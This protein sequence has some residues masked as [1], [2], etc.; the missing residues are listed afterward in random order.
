MLFSAFLLVVGAF[1]SAGS[2]PSRPA[3]RL[4]PDNACPTPA[5]EASR[6]N[7]VCEPF[8]ETLAPVPGYSSLLEVDG[9]LG[10]V[11]HFTGLTIFDLTNPAQPVATGHLIDDE[12]WEALELRAPLLFAARGGGL[13]IWDLSNPAQP[14]RLGRGWGPPAWFA[15][16]IDVAGDIAFLSSTEG[17][18]LFD[19]ADP[20]SPA[21]VRDILPARAEGN[22]ILQL[23]ARGSLLTIVSGSGMLE[24]YDISNPEQ[25]VRLGTVSLGGGFSSGNL[26]VRGHRAWVTSPRGF[27]VVDLSAPASPVVLHREIR[28]ATPTGLAVDRGLLAIL[29]A[30]D[31]A[32]AELMD[33][34]ASA[35]PLSL[36]R[37]PKDT[38]VLEYYLGPGY[39]DARFAGDHLLVAAGG[40]GLRSIAIGDCRPAALPPPEPEFEARGSSR[41]G[42]NR[43]LFSDRS[44]GFP[45]SWLWDFGDGTTSIEPDP[46]HSFSGPGTFRVSLTVANSAGSSS[47]SHDVIVAT[48]TRPSTRFDWTPSSPSPGQAATFAADHAGGGHSWDFG[49]PDSGAANSSTL[50]EPVH[51]F[52]AAGTYRVRLEVTDGTSLPPQA[53]RIVEVSDP[54]ACPTPLL[55]RD[56]SPSYTTAVAADGDLLLRG[57]SWESLL[58]LADFSEPAHPTWTIASDRYSYGDGEGLAVSGDLLVWRSESAK[59]L[60]AQRIDRSIELVSSID[61]DTSRVRLDGPW[62]FAAKGSD[63]RI[64]DLSA[65]RFPKEAATWSADSSIASFTVRGSR[66]FAGRMDGRLDVVDISDRTEPVLLGSSQPL[67]AALTE[68]LVDETVLWARLE[69]ELQLATFDLSSPSTPVLADIQYLEEFEGANPSLALAGDILFVTVERTVELFDVS[70]RLLPRRFGRE[71]LFSDQ[72]SWA[73]S[74]GTG[75]AFVEADFG[76]ALLY[77]PAFCGGA[78]LP[79]GAEFAWSPG[80]IEPGTPVQFEPI[81]SGGAPTRW[82]WDFGDGTTSDREF[83]W[84]RW[85]ESGTHRVRLTVGNDAG[86]ATV[87]HDVVVSPLATPPVAVISAWPTP[88]FAGAPVRFQGGSSAGLAET[89]H[90]DFGDGTTAT[91]GDP[92][93]AFA[94]AG[95]RT[96]TLT[97]GNA[98]GISTAST[99]VRVEALLP[100]RSRITSDPPP[101]SDVVLRSDGSL[102]LASRSDRIRIIDVSDMLAIRQVGVIAATV[103]SSAYRDVDLFGKVAYVLTSSNQVVELW[104]LSTPQTPSKIGSLS[105]TG[106]VAIAVGDDLLLARRGE[107]EVASFLLSDPR[108]PV[109]AGSI[110]GCSGSLFA[111]SGRRAVCAADRS[112]TV[113]D[114][115]NPST[116]KIVGPFPLETGIVESV[117]L[118]G[119]FVVATIERSASPGSEIA[120]LS[121]PDSGPPS[122][123]GSIP[124]SSTYD[125][126]TVRLLSAN[127]L[128]RRSSTKLEI[129][130]VSDPLAPV[131]LFEESVPNGSDLGLVGDWLFVSELG[132]STWPVAEWTEPSDRSLVLPGAA[133]ADGQ[134]GSRWRSDLV[135]TNPSPEPASLLVS[136]RPFPGFPATATTSTFVAPARGT[137][138]LE[139]LLG[140]AF[141]LSSG[142]GVVAI[143]TAS[144]SGVTPLV[145]MRTYNDS[146]TGTFGQE[147]PAMSASHASSRESVRLLP[148]LAADSDF[149]SN[150]GIVNLDS[151]ELEVEVLL[152]TD[153]GLPVGEPFRVRLD[154]L[155]ATQLSGLPQRAGFDGPLAA[156]RAQVRRLAGGAFS[157]YG[158]RIDNRSGDP[159]FVPGDLLGRLGGPLPG[160]ARSP[161]AGGTDWRS[162]LVAANTTDRTATLAVAFTKPDGSRT[163]GQFGPVAVGGELDLP[164]LLESLGVA[165]PASGTLEIDSLCPPYAVTYNDDPEGTYGQTILPVSVIHHSSNAPPLEPQ[166]IGG[167]RGGGRFR[168]NLGFVAVGGATQGRTVRLTLFDH[169]GAEVASTVASLGTD[170]ARQAPLA[171]WIAVPDDF[172]LGSLRVEALDTAHVFAY[173]SIVDNGTGD[174]SFVPGRTTAESASL[175]AQPPPVGSGTRAGSGIDGCETDRPSELRPTS[176]GR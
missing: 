174:P 136:Y 91:I 149:R 37:L 66:L 50:A 24:T 124:L 75:R 115:E 164:D 31:D 141:G 120:L 104:D 12:S 122:R 47:I 114:F 100:A 76:T 71:W 9:P 99:Q 157:C 142:A 162:R 137:L 127:R 10:V 28:S 155:G 2:I 130:D 129:L 163:S 69:S 113:V 153:T 57:D 79:P 78:P 94:S 116:P 45:S 117:D 17:V 86:S 156:F 132:R 112:I 133:R 35:V 19:V 52:T 4:H 173:A 39:L 14:R 40:S 48:G 147:I 108:V 67:G 131:R 88:A 160:I 90:W 8:F 38:A 74:T 36:G 144:P 87:E 83:P 21:F 43:V 151:S 56:L 26:A 118:A 34:A 172:V 49:D 32:T 159:V 152:T 92:T 93:H 60:V 62:L 107:S 81:R 95:L 145:W 171:Q 148:G 103:G 22:E 166:W 65:P 134:G 23:A 84:H 109:P 53:T 18:A 64:F 72:D 41:A 70:N 73:L 85:A 27:S 98:A 158:S 97:V 5:S 82:L 80:A 1:A 165:S 170:S 68:L 63:L 154:G 126:G 101:F 3:V 46:D 106:V 121:F 6:P 77:G 140:T 25:V 135:V 54:G 143:E 16:D 13:E 30:D 168:T 138:L 176:R 15:F 110:T 125:V 102:A 111:V 119:E 42:E 167:I 150:L 89:F 61:L 169:Q 33:V 96:V 146:D 51:T 175:F 105:P 44:D 161:G 55:G 58:V 59:Y 128:A 7:A 20:S 11:A 123:I 139:D 29:D